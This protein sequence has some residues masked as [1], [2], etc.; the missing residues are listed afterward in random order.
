M[1]MTWPFGAV[2][3][4]QLEGTWNIRDV[5]ELNHTKDWT[6]IRLGLNR[7]QDNICIL[8]TRC[9]QTQQVSYSLDLHLRVQFF[10]PGPQDH[11]YLFQHYATWFL[12]FT[13]TIKPA[14]LTY[15]KPIGPAISCLRRSHRKESP[16]EY[17]FLVQLNGFAIQVLCMGW[18]ASWW[19]LICILNPN[20]PLL[21]SSH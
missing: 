16:L 12:D 7:D 3:H 8:T 14:N 9:L 11:E 4:I 20:V 17:L 1:P 10:H 2:Q 21:F 6:P 5:F 13:R 15:F 19:H 18:E